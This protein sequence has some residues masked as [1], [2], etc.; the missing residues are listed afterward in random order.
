MMDVGLVVV[1]TV[2]FMMMTVLVMIGIGL[3][4]IVGMMIT[5]LTLMIESVG[6]W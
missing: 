6:Q 5:V 4:A 3:M 2:A 1:A